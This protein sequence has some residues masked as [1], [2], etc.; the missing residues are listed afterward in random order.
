MVK[1]KIRITF[2]SDSGPSSG[3]EAEAE[4]MDLRDPGGDKFVAQYLFSELRMRSLYGEYRLALPAVGSFVREV[5]QTFRFPE[6]FESTTFEDRI[7]TRRMWF[8]IGKTLMRVEDLLAKSRAYHEIEVR[9]RED[10]NTDAAWHSHL[11]KM[12]HFNLAVVLLIKVGDLALRLIFERLGASLIPTLD[13][14]NPEWERDLTWGRIKEGFKNRSGNSNLAALSEEEY[15]SLRKIL[16][17]FHDG[18]FVKRILRYRHRFIHRIIPS[19]DDS[20][21][22]TNLR[23]REGVPINDE[24]GQAKGWI[25]TFGGPPLAEFSFLALYEDTVKTLKHYISML[26][27][28][29]AIPRFSPE[30]IDVKTV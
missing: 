8:E 16:D 13:R 14:S 5:K 4:F 2:E 20:R 22:Y 25:K 1:A 10:A 6:D 3:F 24:T 29:H 9:F 26:E 28:L 21:L 19:V 30:A 18:G 15:K 11:S 27:R 7:N 23:D 17:D 12:N